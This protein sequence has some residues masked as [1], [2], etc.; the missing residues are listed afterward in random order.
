[1]SLDHLPPFLQALLQPERYDHT[2]PDLRLVVH[3]PQGADIVPGQMLD[4]FARDHVV[5]EA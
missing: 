2:A 4:L 5:L 3:L 1:M